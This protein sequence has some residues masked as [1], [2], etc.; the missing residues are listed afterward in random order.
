MLP[1][2]GSYSV[3]WFVT[4]KRNKKSENK[5]KALEDSPQWWPEKCYKGGTR[6]QMS[7][8]SSKI[9]YTVL[10]D[11]KHQNESTQLFISNWWKI[12]PVSK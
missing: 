3:L 12:W 6:A 11:I 5:I 9:I 1:L 10:E 2:K 8:P 4:T 7:P